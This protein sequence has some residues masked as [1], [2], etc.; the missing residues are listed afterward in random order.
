MAFQF[1]NWAQQLTF[2][3]LLLQIGNSPFWLGVGGAGFASAQLALGPLSGALA[4]SWERRRVLQL[5]QVTA[6][7]VNATI[8]ALLALGWL[9]I[10]HL[11]LAS[12]AMGAAFS[13]NMPARESLMAEIVPRKLLHN[14]T[15]LHTASLNLSRITG[16]AMAGTL[17]AVIGPLYVLLINLVANCWTVRQLMLVRYRPTRPTKP[18]RPRADELLGGFRYFLRHPSLLQALLAICAANFFGAAYVYLY[19]PSRGRAAR[20]TGRIGFVTASMGCGALTGSLLL[21]SRAGLRHKQLVIGVCGIILPLLVAL[22]GAP[23][24]WA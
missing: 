8:L 14:A 21:A 20:R 12:A 2:G 15:A 13:L 18:F 6:L 17:I 16:P 5:T 3:V 9:Q 19:R 24:G 1:Q 22:A 11:V 10:W 7:T 4:D 23:P